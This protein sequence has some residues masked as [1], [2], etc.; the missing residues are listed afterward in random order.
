MAIPSYAGEASF[1]QSLGTHLD[2]S[3]ELSAVLLADTF[4]LGR[5]P[6]SGEALAV[7][8]YW[9]EDVLNPTTVTSTAAVNSSATTL[10]VASATG[11]AIG[12]LLIDLATAGG[13]EVLQ[14]TAISGLNLTVVRGAGDSGPV[15][16]AHASGAI[17]RIIGSPKQEGDETVTDLSLVRPR[18]G[19]TCQIFKKEVAISGTLMAVHLAGVPD[20]YNYQLA[21][22]T[23]ELRRDLGMSVYG[24]VQITAGGSNGSATVIRSMDG[25]RNRI[26][27]GQTLASYT[28][29]GTLPQ[30]PTD[31][32]FSE[33]LI[34]RLYRYIYN[35]GAEATFACSTADQMTKFSQLY[36]DEVRL[37]PSDRQRGVFVTKYLTDMGVE[38][39]LIIDRWALPGDIVVGDERRLRLTPLK[40]RAWQATPLAK[41]G[42][43][44]RGMIVGEYT[45]EVRNAAQ[46]FSMDN[47]LTL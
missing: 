4:L 12:S 24:A 3:D 46:A 36:K 17:F 20:E 11:V 47:S 41:Q 22:R 44:W 45:L 42:D 21:H 19:N 7:D 28:P 26:L 23:L 33:D 6:V 2:L 35:Q 13:G 31:T 38:L 1:G 39:D 32:A 9:V 8:H 34:N 16:V 43:S 14:V 30:I 10:A 40:G 27:R 5:I 25:I 29:Q 37:A 15:A 18:I